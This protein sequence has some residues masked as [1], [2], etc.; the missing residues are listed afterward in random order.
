MANNSSTKNSPIKNSNSTT[1]LDLRGFSESE[2]QGWCSDEA[3]LDDPRPLEPRMRVMGRE[4]GWGFFPRAEMLNGRLAMLGFVIGVLVEAISGQGILGQI[5]LG[6]LL[7][8]H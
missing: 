7:P 2:D 5:G 3:G 4:A 6:S 1:D 8:H